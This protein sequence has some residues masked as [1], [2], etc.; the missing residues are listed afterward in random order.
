MSVSLRSNGVKARQTGVSLIELMVGITVGLI[1]LAGVVTVVS[2]T[3]F[4]GLQNVRS[5]QLDQQLRGAMDFIQRDLQRAGYVKAWDPDPL[6][7]SPELLD[8]LDF[9]AISLFGPV[10]LGTCTAG[11]CE[12][13]LYSYDRD[14]DGLQGVGPAGT[15]GTGQDNDNFELFGFRLDAVSNAI[16]MRVSGDAHECNSGG[17]QDIT[18]ASVSVTALSFEH[19]IVEDINPAPP[20]YYDTVNDN[21]KTYTVRDEGGDSCES[22]ATPPDT[23]TCG[24]GDTCLDRRKLNIVIDGELASDASVTF[25]IRN[26][27]KIKNDYYYVV[28]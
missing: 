21:I 9:D 17:W 15:P 2:K 14:N 7:A 23:C 5:V 13:V 28:P 10:T 3:T 22:D 12:C 27:V 6:D 25:R 19:G 11:L 1:I 24:S 26:Q 20:L 4:S 8:Y 18:D 16:E